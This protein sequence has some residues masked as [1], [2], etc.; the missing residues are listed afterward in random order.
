[1]ITAPFRAL[2][3][4]R[5]CAFLVGVA[6]AAPFVAAI[7][8]TSW[9]RLSFLLLLPFVLHLMMSSSR[10]RRLHVPKIVWIALALLLL[11]MIGLFLGETPYWR[12]V[13]KESIVGL[14]YMVFFLLGMNSE[15][16]PYAI[17]HGFLAV[18]IF[19]SVPLSAVA[20]FKAAL[21]ERGIMLEFLIYPDRLLYPAGSSLQGD[22]NL[23][24]LTLLVAAF[25]L[26]ALMVRENRSRRVVAFICFALAVVYTA[27]LL[28]GSRRV[29]LL[30]A[31]VPVLW[32]VLRLTDFKRGR[33]LHDLVVPVCATATCV[34]VLFWVVSSKDQSGIPQPTTPRSFASLFSGGTKEAPAPQTEQASPA[35]GLANRPNIEV[36]DANPALL[37]GTIEHKKSYGLD[38]R[39]ERWKFA[40]SLIADRGWFLGGGFAYH[41]QFSCR[42][43][44]CAFVDYP[45]LP[46]L[47]E[48]IVGGVLGAL[49]ATA[50]Y[51]LLLRAM[52]QAGS[53]GWRSGATAVG[54]SVIPF[55]MISGDTVFSMPQFL[56]ACLL[57]QSVPQPDPGT[58][59]RTEAHAGN[60]HR[61][62]DLEFCSGSSLGT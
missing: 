5:N 8:P 14:T 59:D 22:Y 17:I 26:V 24:G 4:Q 34:T 35:G 31:F 11:H 36:M 20:L 47:S 25:A 46:I 33:L 6:L 51:A 44:E 13:L 15:Q 23:F 58:S 56:I 39:I 3:D 48:W 55:S 1:M 9:R 45:H 53:G 40:T 49:L 28:A 60:T 37:L 21:L 52:W 43:V 38:T 61:H 27:C 29:L 62:N 7:L 32:V 10:I 19:V 2:K 30:S 41:T 18:L 16:R 50:M 42:F 54:L 12:S 57:L